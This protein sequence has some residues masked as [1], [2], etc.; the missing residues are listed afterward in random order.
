MLRP[1]PAA[2]P[3]PQPVLCWRGS[4]QPQWPHLSGKP[5]ATSP[6]PSPPSPE[7]RSTAWKQ[8]TGRGRPRAVENRTQEAN[9]SCAKPKE[10][11]LLIETKLKKIIP[12]ILLNSFHPFKSCGCC[13]IDDGGVSSHQAGLGCHT[14]HLELNAQPFLAHFDQLWPGTN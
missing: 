5:A 14:N 2:L 4:D 6:A 12:E 1:E 7:P 3:S 10:L 13:S 9:I 11:K 8:R